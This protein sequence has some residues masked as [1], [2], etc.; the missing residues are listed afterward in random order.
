MRY[1]FEVTKAD[2]LITIG[3]CILYTTNLGLLNGTI[4]LR[5]KR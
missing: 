1:R 5:L 4:S 2:L 3:A